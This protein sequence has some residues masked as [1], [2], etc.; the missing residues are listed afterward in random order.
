MSRIGLKPIPVPDKVAIALNKS[1]VQV[2]G[3][4]GSLNWNL[5][6]GIDVT[7]DENVLSV[8]RKSELKQYKAL[9]GLARSLNR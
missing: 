9:H 7:L 2:D 8:Q 5:P 6:D 4:K 1:N 3:P